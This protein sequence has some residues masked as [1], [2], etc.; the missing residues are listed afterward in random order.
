MHPVAGGRPI[1]NKG[2]ACFALTSAR[3]LACHGT[4]SRLLTQADDG[5]RTRNLPL[6][7]RLLCRLSYVGVVKNAPARARRLYQR[8]VRL[9]RFSPSRSMEKRP[10][11]RPLFP[12]RPGRL[13]IRIRPGG[14]NPEF[15]QGRSF[16]RPTGTNPG[17]KDEGLPTGQT[18]RRGGC[19]L[20]PS[21]HP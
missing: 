17:G 20:S 7:R 10:E 9:T 4:V 6:T 12:I 19:G 14:P 16:T 18:A 11:K 2:E 15:F 13:G 8:G 1:R 5:N 21:P 3:S